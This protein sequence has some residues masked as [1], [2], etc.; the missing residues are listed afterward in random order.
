MGLIRNVTGCLK[1]NLWQTEENKNELVK[2]EVT[3][4]IQV[5][6]DSIKNRNIT[7]RC[8]RVQKNTCEVAFDFG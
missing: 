5:E 6:D 4:E 3:T 8:S 7:A 2:K 1:D